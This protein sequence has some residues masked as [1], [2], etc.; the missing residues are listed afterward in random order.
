[1]SCVSGHAGGYGSLFCCGAVAGQGEKVQ[2]FDS[3]QLRH[4][5][6]TQVQYDTLN[7]LG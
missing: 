4:M 6:Q 2:H 5:Q 7:R 3:L 1:M